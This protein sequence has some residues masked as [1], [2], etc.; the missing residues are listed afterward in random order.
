MTKT[1]REFAPEFKREAVALLESSG[2]PLMLEVA[3]EVGISPSMLRNWRWQPSTP[4][5]PVRERSWQGR[6]TAVPG[7]PGCR[8]CAAEAGSRSNAH[9]VR[10]P[11]KSHRHLRGG[12]QMRFTFI[13]DH[14]GT[15]PIRLMCR[16]LQ[17]S[18]SG[19]YA[20]RGSPQTAP[21]SSPTASP[22]SAMSGVSRPSIVAV[23]WLAEDAHRA[24]C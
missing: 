6:T 7:R 17:V 21:G 10:R 9:G 12:A 4:A 22:C 3:T 13:R 1:R 23:A 5:L 18:A 16:V 15:W 20:W 2:R 19:Y 24:S 11:K 14:A 8:D